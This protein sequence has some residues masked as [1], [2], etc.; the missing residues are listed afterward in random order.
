MMDK[1]TDDA[2]WMPYDDVIVPYSQ[3]SEDE[4]IMAQYDLRESMDYL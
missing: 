3:L 2:E 4:Q 1:Y